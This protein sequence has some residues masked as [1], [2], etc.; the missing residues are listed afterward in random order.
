MAFCPVQR[1]I[2]I[3]A[4]NKVFDDQHPVLGIFLDRINGINMILRRGV[5]ARERDVWRMEVFDDD[6][7]VVELI[8]RR[9]LH[10]NIGLLSVVGIPPN[11]HIGIPHLINQFL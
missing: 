11:G 5:P 10:D 1:E 9:D 2:I 6:H 8:I 4:G 3:C 7:Q